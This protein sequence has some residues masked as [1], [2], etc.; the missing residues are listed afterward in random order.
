M[1]GSCSESAGNTNI[2]STPLADSMLPMAQHLGYERS[3]DLIKDFN[4][5]ISLVRM[6]VIK[7]DLTREKVRVNAEKRLDG[8]QQVFDAVSF[9]SGTKPIFNKYFDDA[10][11]S[12]LEDLSERFDAQKLSSSDADSLSVALGEVKELANLAR[13]SGELSRRANRLISV[14]LDH[15]AGILKTYETL[16]ERDF[17]DHYRVLFS[18]FVELHESLFRDVE[19][20]KEYNDRLKSM[21]HC[22]LTGSSLTANAITIAAAVLPALS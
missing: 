16:G 20:P 19:T 22:L 9:K 12:A 14:H 1:E 3:L 17:W 5:R 11:V 2:G 6:D 21:L 8:L 15:L 10:N 13:T 7:L 18:S 4:D